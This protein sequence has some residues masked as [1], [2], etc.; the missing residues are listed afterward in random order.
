MSDKP[1]I[2]PSVQRRNV[3][4]TAGAAGLY[5]LGSGA[6]AAEKSGQTVRFVNSAV[7]YQ[8]E[9]EQDAHIQT[10]D[11]DDIAKHT[12]SPADGMLDVKKWLLSDEERNLFEE[13]KRILWTGQYQQWPTTVL[14]DRPVDI[15]PTE[16]IKKLRV[17]EGFSLAQKLTPPTVRLKSDGDD[18]V[19][20]TR[21]QSTVVTP[22][23][24]ETVKLPE[25]HIIIQ[26]N[27]STDSSKV[28]GTAIPKI[29]VR[30]FGQLTVQMHER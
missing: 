30:N 13:S 23:E 25:Q 29:S 21:E 4:K 6:A 14:G 18:A 7:T 15:T 17:A 3:L 28:D 8:I 22:G 10:V 24:T 26:T 27:G 20:S 5:A 16:R 1:T 11:I 12:V 9:T 19:V 2:N